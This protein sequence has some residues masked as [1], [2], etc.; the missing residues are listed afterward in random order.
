MKKQLID[1]IC[2]GPPA[3]RIRGLEGTVKKRCKDW[4]TSHQFGQLRQAKNIN[5]CLITVF[6]ACTT[7][8]PPG[9]KK[10]ILWT[11]L[12][13]DVQSLRLN[14]THYSFCAFC[15]VFHAFPNYHLTY[16]RQSP[17]QT[18]KHWIKWMH[19]LPCRAQR[20]SGRFD[21]YESHFYSRH[22]PGSCNFA[23]SSR[24]GVSFRVVFEAFA[25]ISVAPISQNLI[26]GT[27]WFIFYLFAELIQMWH[28]VHQICTLMGACRDWVSDKRGNPL[29]VAAK[30]RKRGR[31][32]RKK[33]WGEGGIVI[34]LLLQITEKSPLK[35]T[36]NSVQ[37]ERRSRHSLM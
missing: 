6:I 31:R 12:K 10:K 16:K 26:T 20:L 1:F 18:N 23:L 13:H 15:T 2:T 32:K 11:D 19:T 33:D 30:M 21:E 9:E 36:D 8:Y 27:P 5:V 24:A 25:W 7:N 4:T 37:S 3:Y 14:G 34:L 35:C 28:A 29:V 17:C 22:R